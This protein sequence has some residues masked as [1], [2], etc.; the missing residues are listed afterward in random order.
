M[1]LF[2]APPYTPPR[3]LESS[4]PDTASL[5]WEFY[6]CGECPYYRV[7]S[8]N[9][10]NAEYVG[11]MVYLEGVDVWS[12]LCAE[13]DEDKR[14]EIF[15]A[16]SSTDKF[17]CTGRFERF[18]TPFI[19]WQCCMEDAENIFFQAETCQQLPRT[20]EERCLHNRFIFESIHHRSLDELPQAA[21]AGEA[22]AQYLLGDVYEQG[23][24]CYPQD[25]ALAKYWY[26]Q[27][28][29]QGHKYAIESLE[30]MRKEEA[31]G[32]LSEE[33]GETL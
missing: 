17:V 2:S 27:A 13:L 16:K 31:S 12:E 32:G 26:E 22:E 30:A 5:V 24:P 23:I 6:A 3:L 25:K 21:E 1:W 7:L 11:K 29:S 10:E 20:D 9:Q 8:A 14:A 18:E 4:S 33:N 19:N 15:T 28:A